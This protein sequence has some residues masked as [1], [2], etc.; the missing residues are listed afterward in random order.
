MLFSNKVACVSPAVG[1]ENET[2]NTLRYANRAQ[3]IENI[4]IMKSDSR[5][6]IVQKLKR[7]LRKLKEENQTLKQQL[8]YPNV[9]NSGRLPKIVT[10][11]NGNNTIWLL[12]SSKTLILTI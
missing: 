9:N 8:G 6:N 5:E 11:R 3:N 12:F 4:P 2:L 7:E 1:S 10:A